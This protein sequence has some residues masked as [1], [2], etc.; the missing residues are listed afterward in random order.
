MSTLSIP[1]GYP[2]PNEA[3]LYKTVAASQ[4]TSPLGFVSTGSPGDYIES[5]TV[6]PGSSVAGAWTLFDGTTTVLAVPAAAGGGVPSPYTIFL[7]ARANSRW[8]ITTGAAVSVV[9]IGSFK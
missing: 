2:A 6:S 5:I 8:N 7:G 3:S 9:V 1:P 4:T